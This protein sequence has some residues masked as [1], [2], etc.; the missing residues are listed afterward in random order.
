MDSTDWY[1]VSNRLA[2]T[3]TTIK[4]IAAIIG[5]RIRESFTKYN[6][7]RTV[8]NKKLAV[9]DTSSQFA[10]HTKLVHII[11]SQCL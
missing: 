6:K 5:P 8:P 3:I 7:T 9:S 2:P 10:Q 1:D 4:P 11:S